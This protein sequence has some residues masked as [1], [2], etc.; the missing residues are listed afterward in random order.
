MTQGRGTWIWEGHAPPNPAKS[1][2]NSGNRRNV[3]KRFRRK[4]EAGFE[5]ARHGR[6]KMAGGMF[7]AEETRGRLPHHRYRK[8][9]TQER[10]GVLLAV[11]WNVRALNRIRCV[12]EAAVMPAAAQGRPG[13][14]ERASSLAAKL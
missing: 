11:T 9:E 8:K 5:P 2:E 14:E 4:A 7:G 3:G 1:G 12:Q 13:L 6:R 10:F